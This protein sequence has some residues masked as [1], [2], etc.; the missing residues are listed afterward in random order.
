MGTRPSYVLD[1]G[2][3]SLLMVPPYRP[4]ALP[5]Y[6]PT[7]IPP[8][9][10]TALPPCRPLLL[11]LHPQLPA[12]RVDV[13]PTAPADRCLDALVSEPVRER[14]DAWRCGRSEVGRA[15]GVERKDVHQ[16]PQAARQLG[17]AIRVGVG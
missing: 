17:Q 16:R 6:R 1:F 3:S 2:G 11:H 8:Y 13:E 12:G 7:A 10:P 14:A 15:A 4:T 5:P 9:R